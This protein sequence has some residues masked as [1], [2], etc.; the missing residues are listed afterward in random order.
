MK[1][2]LLIVFFFF[3]S[4]VI[5][6]QEYMKVENVTRETSKGIQQGFLITVKD[7]DF[8]TVQKEWEKSIKDCKFFDVLKKSESKV[9]FSHQGDEYIANNVIINTISSTPIS[10]MATIADI[11]EGIRVI[12]FFQ[13]DSVYISKDNSKE[14]TYLAT[15]NYLRSF[16]IDMLQQTVK[17]HLES[18]ENLL[19][20][21]EN[22]LSK[23]QSKKD[24]YEKSIG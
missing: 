2:Y 18:Q 6:S 5:F 23:L 11:Q 10:V 17:S 20:D 4:T 14:E 19:N 3:L 12:A 24:D 13:L 16:G 7:A 22:E 15:K 8:K 1:S 9:Q 21:L